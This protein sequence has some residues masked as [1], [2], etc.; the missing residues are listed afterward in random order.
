MIVAQ[1]GDADD[2]VRKVGARRPDA[3]VIASA[4]VSASRDATAR[5]GK[6]ASPAPRSPALTR[7]TPRCDTVAMHELDGRTVDVSATKVP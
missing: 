2:L 4:T 3:A 1:A 6:L 7:H 5:V